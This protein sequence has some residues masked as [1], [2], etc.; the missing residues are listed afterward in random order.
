MWLILIFVDLMSFS[1]GFNGFIDHEKVL[2]IMS[3][4]QTKWAY[5]Y[6]FYKLKLNFF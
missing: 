4:N 2:D 6:T 5:F 1:N 3:Q